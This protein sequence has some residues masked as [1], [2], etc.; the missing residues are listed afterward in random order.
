MADINS[1]NMAKALK[2]LTEALNNFK[3][4]GEQRIGTPSILDDIGYSQEHASKGLDGN[5]KKFLNE[6]LKLYEKHNRS[7]FSIF[8]NQRTWKGVYRSFV[9]R[10]QER[11]A[12]RAIKKRFGLEDQKSIDAIYKKMPYQ[13]KGGFLGGIF[14]TLAKFAKGLSLVTFGLQILSDILKA[15]AEARK[16]Y[17]PSIRQ[18]YMTNDLGMLFSKSTETLN[19]LRN[20]LISGMYANNPAYKDA[21]ASI[22]SGGVL[23]QKGIRDSEALVKSFRF[24]ASQGIILGETF[25]DT[26]KN[27]IDAASIYNLGF[28]RNS[29]EGYQ[30]INKFIERGIAEGFSKSSMHKF[31]TGYS[32]SAAVANSG[33]I[34]VL[35]DMKLMF[36]TLNA[37]NPDKNQMP[38]YANVFQNLMSSRLSSLSTFAALVDGGSSYSVAGL[39]KL[40]TQYQDS[41]PLAQKAIALR[42]MLKKAGMGTGENDIALMT[43]LYPEFSAYRSAPA[44]RVLKNLVDN[45]GVNKNFMRDTQNLTPKQ[46]ADWMIKNAGISAKQRSA[47]ERMAQ[48][49]EA[50]TNPL[51]TII[52][53]TTGMLN[54]L[55]SIAGSPVLKLLSL[56]PVDAGPG[57]QYLTSATRT[58]RTLH[59]SRSN[60]FRQRS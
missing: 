3:Q 28:S 40:A 27:F 26:A 54:I 51:Q 8:R 17:V 10:S 39:G 4:Y 5:Q 35:K 7:F 45:M 2:D 42:N 60:T 47:V 12:K 36:N 44:R 19:K 23:N 41:S 31:L 56:S 52:N 32:N 49:T 58:G 6:Q 15:T 24:I 1:E 46:M 29:I 33:L 34:T 13:F 16:F 57:E 22:M 38:A 53:I 50:M 11:L 21:F 9:E 55:Y 43:E 20:P 30:Y 37:V 48:A 25:S 14:T 59:E 18:G